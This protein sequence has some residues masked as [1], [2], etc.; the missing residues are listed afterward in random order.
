MKKRILF[1]LTLSLFAFSAV[2]S[3]AG[4][5]IVTLE[6]AG[7]DGEISIRYDNYGVPHIKAGSIKDVMF[8]QGYVVARDRLWQMDNYRRRV[9]GR[10][11]E[12]FGKGKVGDD[13]QVHLAR[14]PETAQ[15]VWDDYSDEYRSFFQAYSDGVNAY[16]ADMESLPGEYIELGIEPEPWTPLDSVALGRGMVWALSSSVG[17]EVAL[18]VMSKY[19][20]KSAIMKLAPMKGLDPITITGDFKRSD[21]P[22]GS[23]DEKA[24]RRLDEWLYASGRSHFGDPA[25][26][27]SWAVSGSRTESGFPLLA[28]DTHMGLENPPVW[29]EVHM[30]SPEINIY[31]L[32][33]PGIP[34]ILVGHNEHIAWSLTQA[35][36]DVTD[37]YIEK[38]DPERPDT[39][40]I[41]NGESI[42]FEKQDIEIRYKT[43]EGMETETRTLLSTVHGPVIYEDDRPRTVMSFRWTGHEP[44]TETDCFFRLFKAANLADFKEAMSYFQTG[45][46]NFVYAD[47]EGN[48]YYFAP[49]KVPLRRGRPFMPLD[50]STDKYEWQKYIPY[51]R[52]PSS[53]NP[54]EG[55]IVTANNRTVGDDYPY[56]LAAFYDKGFRARRIND[57]LRAK[58]KVTFDYMRRMQGDVYSLPGE[59]LLPELYE[60]AAE[61]PE[62]LDDRA[63]Q[64][65]EILRD[66]D[67]QTG[68]DSIGSSIFH[69]WLKH[70]TLG[71][72]EDDVPAD[73]LR[74]VARDEVVFPMIARTI[75]T[76][77][78]FYDDKKTA[79]VME[80][81][82]HILA[83]ALP[84]AVAEL[85]GMF[86]E[87]MSQWKWRK[88]HKMRLGH[89]LGGDY[90]YGPFENDGAID[91]VDVS[92]FGMLG[93]EYVAGA[94]ASMRMIFE[95]KPGAVRGACVLPGGQSGLKSSPHY[96]DQLQMYLENRTRP[97]LFYEDD[98]AAAVEKT[99]VLKPE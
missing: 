42:P 99:I 74:Q 45:A 65:L 3:V 13:F 19:L 2:P 64:A 35:R 27:N 63:R 20:S 96:N 93:E 57:L 86:G 37:V 50:G 88:L 83:A 24:L 75:K 54:P 17:I 73:V 79:G 62:L 4:T 85:T 89:S 67:Y 44:T 29:F 78:N 69:K 23:I 43:E 66:W 52:L 98:I 55:F 9:T 31:G 41:Y 49:A 18:G 82:S 11:A 40:Y 16:I 39:H 7:I 6:M 32:T 80:S 21:F 22:A 76:P 84:D 8:A 92:A 72:F 28:N 34:G 59:R 91:T 95:M 90:N 70:C 26:S 14:L 77:L 10:R 68:L 47:V 58:E 94:G 60:A 51:E 87:D 53:L 48:I 15:E 5:D 81:R 97:I 12:I 61:H 71:I 46:Q 25:G 38:L 33:S 36:H 1:F 30:Q 56:Y